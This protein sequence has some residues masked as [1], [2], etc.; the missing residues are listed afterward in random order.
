[1]SHTTLENC[2]RTNYGLMHKHKWDLD[3]FEC[4]PIWE[5]NIYLDMLIDDINKNSKEQ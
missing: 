5:A 2:L 1:M 4:L 3:H